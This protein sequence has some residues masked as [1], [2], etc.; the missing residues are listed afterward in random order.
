MAITSN[1]R[2]G[3]CPTSPGATKA[4]ARTSRTA[5]DGGSC[6]RGN[7]RGSIPETYQ[8]RPKRSDGR[9]F[10]GVAALELLDPAGGVHDLLLAG[11]VRVRFRG[12]LH[13]DHRILLAVG[14]LHFLAALG[15]DDGA[16]QEGMVGR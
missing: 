2:Q 16:R 4:S 6:I 9:F 10:L 14:P 12:D 8:V 11:V 1:A 7:C 3:S 13:L 5:C 15:V